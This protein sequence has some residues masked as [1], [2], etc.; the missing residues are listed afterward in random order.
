MKMKT[1]SATLLFILPAG[2][3]LFGSL[4]SVTGA[5]AE[6]T[7]I[8]RLTNQEMRLEFSAPSGLN[9]RIESSTNLPQWNSLLTILSSGL[10]QYTD[11][12]APYFQSRY[13][14]AQQLT[15][16]NI[17]T[18]DHLVTDEGDVIIHPINHASFVMSWNGKMIYNDPVVA[19]RFTGLS[20][21]DLVLISHAHGDHFDT[22]A[23]S[24]VKNSNAVI[25]APS[26]VYNG[27]PSNL[28]SNT[29]VMAN[30]TSTNVLGLS[31]AA[32]PAYNLTIPINHPQGVGNGYVLTVGGKRIYIAGDTE[33]IPE[34]RALSSID[35]AFV[36]MNRPF[37]MTVS[38]AVSAVREFRPKVVYP[39]HYS[40]STPTTDL[41]LF[42]R[43]V[44]T[45]LG[46][47]VRLG[48]W[49]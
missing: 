32:V 40:P 4:F 9:Y 27:L 23:I 2:I 45:D 46:V 42:K 29:I 1:A 44:G 43:Q 10:N 35:V 22:A 18:G 48:K 11:S 25:I 8:Q 31:V 49:Y 17:L 3:L 13:Y 7:G 34:M 38:N 33:D 21:A 24:A 37:T 36:P 19:A 5:D 15:G 41:N 39:Y 12:A 16:T 28:R 47:E 30:G 14:R 20:R 6:F 26:I